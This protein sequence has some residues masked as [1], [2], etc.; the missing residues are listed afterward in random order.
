M[1]DNVSEVKALSEVLKEGNGSSQGA[2][3]NG[4]KHAWDLQARELFAE[5]VKR[6]IEGV[7]LP[8]E[9]LII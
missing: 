1:E 5:G 7:E 8:E 3:L 2:K 6:W 9:Y 4:M